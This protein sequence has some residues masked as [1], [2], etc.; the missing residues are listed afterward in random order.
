MLFILE[1]ACIANMYDICIW[2]LLL[3]YILEVYLLVA[4]SSTALTI[5]VSILVLRIYHKSSI[6]APPAF[7]LKICNI[8]DISPPDTNA[9]TVKKDD[10]RTKDEGCRHDHLNIDSKQVNLTE[11]L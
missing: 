1:L 10:G 6:Q 5:L 3:L 4:L 8:N 2:Y 7:L 9:N 11:V